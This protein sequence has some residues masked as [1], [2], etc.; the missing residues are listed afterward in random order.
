M[1]ITL[2]KVFKYVGT[3]IGSQ[4]AD[5]GSEKFSWM[6]FLRRGTDVFHLTTHVFRCQV[7]R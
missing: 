2:T 7:V 5:T 3:T 4:P 1:S 6:G